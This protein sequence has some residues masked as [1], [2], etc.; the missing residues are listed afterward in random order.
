MILYKTNVSIFV[1]SI[2]IYIEDNNWILYIKHLCD[3][4]AK[5]NILYVIIN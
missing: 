4:L 1:S 2:N 5:K 3:V